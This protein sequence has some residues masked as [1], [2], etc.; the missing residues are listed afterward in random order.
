MAQK[1]TIVPADTPNDGFPEN[2]HPVDEPRQNVGA[3]TNGPMISPQSPSPFYAASIPYQMQLPPDIMPTRFPGG[4]GGYRVM[5]VGPSGSAGG[6]SAV[7]SAVQ[8]VQSTLNTT[9]VNIDGQVIELETDGIP[10]ADQTTLNLFGAGGTRLTNGPGGTEIESQELLNGVNA[11]DFNIP[12][13]KFNQLPSITAGDTLLTIDPTLGSTFQPSDVGDCMYLPGLGPNFT[14]LWTTIVSYIS[15]TQV[16][17]ATPITN[18][19]S[20]GLDENF[21]FCAWGQ[22]AGTAAVPGFQDCIPALTLALQAANTIR[23]ACYIPTGAYCYASAIDMNTVGPS[24][25]K[26]YGDGG[27]GISTNF[28]A[29]NPAIATDHGLLAPTGLT[30]SDFYGFSVTGACFPNPAPGG[31]RTAGAEVGIWTEGAVSDIGC[32]NSSFTRGIHVRVTNSTASRLIVNENAG[33]LY[34][35]IDGAFASMVSA[36]SIFLDSETQPDAYANLALGGVLAWSQAGQQERL[37]GFAAGIY[38]DASPTSG[39]VTLLGCY[40]FGNVPPTTGIFM[41]QGQL[42]GCISGDPSAGITTPFNV[43][44]ACDVISCSLSTNA[45]TFPR[46]PTTFNETVAVP[47]GINDGSPVKLTAQAATIAPTN[48][49]AS[50]VATTVYELAYV[51]E[52]TTAG[53]GGTVTLS[54]TWNNGASQTTTTAIVALNTLGSFQAGSIFVKAAT[55]AIQYATTVSAATGSPKYSLDIRVLPRG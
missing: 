10:N 51:I 34:L 29:Q 11:A 50:P 2:W 26:F 47:I 32:Y 15:M 45:S 18:A 13:L 6:N 39:P 9:N 30:G 41:S 46:V 52:T 7:N 3:P 4:L 49:V 42:I 40:V 48:L 27:I 44:T 20:S 12:V 38:Y 14:D 8:S 35:E 22:N 54:F 25:T 17:I 55:G 1:P 31:G 21:N 37:Q 23:G 24:V 43:G 36:P 19:P 16:Q 5:P 28:I 53:S 33:S